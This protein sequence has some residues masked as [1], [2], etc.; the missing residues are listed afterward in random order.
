[1]TATTPTG[2]PYPE[3]TDRV[4]DGDDA[5]HALASRLDTL[6]GYGIA[7]GV[8]LTPVPPA[9][10]TVVSVPVVFPAGRFTKPPTVLVS[11]N[12]NHPEAVGVTS[13]VVT[14]EGFTALGARHTGPLVEI[15]V[16]WIAHDHD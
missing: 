8:A 1:M 11:S 9:Y 16:M 7:S 5:I 2:W 3:G 6:L 12:A 15:Q 13:S 10:D 14:A 4:M